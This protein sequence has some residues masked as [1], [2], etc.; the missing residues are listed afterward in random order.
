MATPQSFDE[1]LQSENVTVKTPVRGKRA[2]DEIGDNAVL[3][4]KAKQKKNAAEAEK[5]DVKR[6][7][8]A[9]SEVQCK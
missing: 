9:I 4:P 1:E 6:I 5:E 8:T 3:E 7:Q 2:I